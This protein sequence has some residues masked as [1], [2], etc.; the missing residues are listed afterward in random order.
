MRQKVRL[1]ESRIPMRG[2]QGTQRRT[3]KEM[4]WRECYQHVLGLRLRPLPVLGPLFP[5]RDVIGLEVILVRL[6]SPS[7]ERLTDEA[8]CFH[9]SLEVFVFIV[10]VFTSYFHTPMDPKI[11]V[12]ERFRRNSLRTRTFLG[13]RTRQANADKK[14]GMGGLDRKWGCPGDGVSEGEGE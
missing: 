3:L 1:R 10:K 5:K 4:R 14:K 13:T 8:S 11:E 6:W 7:I 9:V 12:Q 2:V